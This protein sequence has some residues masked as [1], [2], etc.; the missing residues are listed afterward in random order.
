[1]AKNI[2]RKIV[3]NCH[4]MKTG[5]CEMEGVMSIVCWFFV[6]GQGQDYFLT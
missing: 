6:F 5:V 2:N 4:K 1:M 3:A